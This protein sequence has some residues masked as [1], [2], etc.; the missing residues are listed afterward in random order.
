MRASDLAGKLQAGT[1]TLSPH[2]TPVQIAEALL[3]SRPASIALTVP[4][5]WRL[6]QI[7]DALRARRDGRRSLSATIKPA[8]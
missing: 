6:E 7:A 5:G 8:I 4:E 1:Y 2:L 3:H